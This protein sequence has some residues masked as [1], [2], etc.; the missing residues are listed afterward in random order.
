MFLKPVANDGS[1]WQE[2]SVDINI[3]SPKGCVPLTHSYIHLLNHEKMFIKSEVE[4][5]YF[6]LAANELSDEAFLLTSKYWPEW[7]VC[8]YWGYM[9][10]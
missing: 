8:P 2:V 9:H 6:D 7:V 10:V 5:I 4:E 3:L 1:E